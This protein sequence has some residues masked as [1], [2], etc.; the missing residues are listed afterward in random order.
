MCE[1]LEMN[2]GFFGV[3]GVNHDDQGVGLAGPL[4]THDVLGFTIPF[5]FT[6]VATAMK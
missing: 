4:A 1:V 2:D 6:S 5:G 3:G